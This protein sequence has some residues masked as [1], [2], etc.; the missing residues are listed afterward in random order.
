[1]KEFAVIFDMDGVLVDSNPM[2]K[3]SI[4]K[5]TAEHDVEL[6]EQEL[7]EKVYGRNNR[8]WIPYLF[9][10]ED[11]APERVKKYADQKEEMFREMYRSTI[12][13]LP[14]LRDFLDGLRAARVSYAIATSAPRANV[15]F[16]LDQTG[17]TR[18][19]TTILHE[20][21]FDKGKPDPEI[22][23]NTAAA[24]R[25]DP[26]RCIVFEDSLAGVASGCRAG[27]KVVGIT[28]T[29][30]AEELKEKGA[31]ATFPDFRNIT[32]ALL[33]KYL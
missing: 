30:T 12:E 26:A 8:E 1:M 4:E 22:Y 29:Q 31:V 20:A 28:T 6:S 24:L 18:Y 2:H 7:K 32:P 27:C 21:H 3:K 16:T 11:M 13:L 15:D 17:I 19:F 9:H 23:L 5:F 33:E 25:F 14:G 10:D